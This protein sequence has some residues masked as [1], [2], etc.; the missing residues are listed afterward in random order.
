MRSMQFGE[1][2]LRYEQEHLFVVAHPIRRNYMPMFMEFIFLIFF[3][4][5]IHC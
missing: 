5:C 4:C 1:F 2:A 3:F